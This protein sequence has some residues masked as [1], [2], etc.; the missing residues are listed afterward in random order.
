VS[1]DFR[2]FLVVDDDDALRQRLADALR[3][4]GHRVQEAGDGASARAASAEG[5]W[6]ILLD[7]R[8]P[9]GDGVALVRDLRAIDSHNEIV[10]LTGYG[11]IAT[12]VD[13]MR[14]GAREYLAKPV[15]VSRILASFGLEDGP[16]TM[17][18]ED[19]ATP[20]L[21]RVEWEHIQR[22]MNDVAGNVSEAARVLGVHRRSLQRKLRR[23][24]AS[25]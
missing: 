4:R 7:L 14:F 18:A 3:Q 15:G 5:P 23:L 9:G 17:R 20:S 13:A 21:D 6:R 24:P 1:L 8:M 2:G 19:P 25:R 11:S 22:V 12:A 16:R 10:V